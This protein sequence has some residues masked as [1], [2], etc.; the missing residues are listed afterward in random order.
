[1]AKDEVDLGEVIRTLLSW[2]RETLDTFEKKEMGIEE[3]KR[4]IESQFSAILKKEREKAEKEAQKI[5]EE[6]ETVSQTEFEK[7]LKKEESE[8]KKFE[9]LIEKERRQIVDLSLDKIVEE[10]EGLV[11]K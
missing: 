7:I 3:S 2:E 4:G 9:K 6:Q 5:L 8:I 10:V 11:S 1:M